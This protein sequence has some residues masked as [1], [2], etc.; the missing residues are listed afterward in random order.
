V[1]LAISN[2]VMWHEVDGGVSLFHLESGEFLALNFS[3]SRIWTLVSDHGLKRDVMSRLIEEFA[4]GDANLAL[5]VVT[6]AKSFIELALANGWMEERA[7]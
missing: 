5:Q 3:G 1:Q 6:D 7:L 4:V 2:N